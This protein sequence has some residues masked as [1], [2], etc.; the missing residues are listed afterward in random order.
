MHFCVHYTFP[1]KCENLKVC[2]YRILII[3]Y[4]T[5]DLQKLPELSKV[6]ACATKL[7]LF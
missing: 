5:L 4:T 3:F 7:N 1:M 6:A 2:T